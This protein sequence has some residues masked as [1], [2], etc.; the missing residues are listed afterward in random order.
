MKKKN[1]IALALS[2]AMVLAL[3][4]CGGN[5]NNN[6]G[7]AGSTPSNN[8]GSGS[9]VVLKVGN[10]VS[11]KDP[12]S[13][14]LAEFEKE[15]EEASG[16]SIDVQLF[17]N[18]AIAGTDADVLDKVRANTLQMGHTTPNCLAALSNMPEYY[19]YGIP[20]L[21]S[22]D[23]ELNTV[24]SSDWIAEVNEAF[25][26]ASGVKVFPGGGVNMGWFGFSATGKQ[27]D[28]IADVAGMAIRIN[29][30]NQMIALAE[31]ANINPQFI[32]FSEVYTALAQHTVDGMVT[33][34]PLFYSNGFYDQLKSILTTHCGESYH[35]Y[36]IN[37]KFYSEL[38]ADQ[39]KV[40][41]D[42]VANLITK[43]RAMEE[44]YLDEAIAAMTEAGVTVKEA[45]AADEEFLANISREK[46][47]WV[48][49]TSLTPVENVNKVLEILGRTNEMQ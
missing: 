46:I 11:E 7:T 42:A 22:T 15:V 44:T 39:Q 45:S 14:C 18:G 26:Q 4:A 17:I 48:P 20:Y 16:G 33:N 32:A 27:L 25:R 41:D 28:S 34:A 37:D 40:L 8:T 30:T 1:L 31:G 36:V 12:F 19:V 2:F 38:S 47:W 49:N 35:L 6:P 29:Q 13:I 9:K 23:E 5:G 3:A 10:T 43:T 21:M 24:A